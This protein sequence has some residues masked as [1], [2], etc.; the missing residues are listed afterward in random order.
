MKIISNKRR[1]LLNSRKIDES[2][3]PQ[4]KYKITTSAKTLKFK[5]LDELEK[6]IGITFSNKVQDQLSKGRVNYFEALK[7]SR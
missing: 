1:D 3:T 7:D 6:S 5:Y 2:L 4:E